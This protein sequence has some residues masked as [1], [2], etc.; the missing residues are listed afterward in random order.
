MTSSW[1]TP[2]QIEVSRLF[3]SVPESSGFAVAG[4]AALIVRGLVQRP[5][6]DIDLFLLDA[7]SPSVAAAAASFEAAMSDKG[8]THDRLI[9]QNEFVRF[10]VNNDREN[11]IVD[12]GRDSPADE[13]PG[14]T[15][16]GPT[17]GA[18]DL[19]AR[20]TLALFGRAE[21]RDFTDVYALARRYGRETLLQWAAAS[22]AGFDLQVFA[23]MVT[24]L[25]RLSDEDLPIDT[26]QI[27]SV[28]GFFSEWANELS[29]R[30]G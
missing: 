28:R 7:D 5:T 25:D 29:M 19:A 13:P 30:D 20:K 27:P 22:D 23:E 12:I 6:R 9:N 15:D 21:P 8:W 16:L 17:L 18:H 11:L 10:L 4:G 24:S 1:L 2:F 3:F 14:D 26:A